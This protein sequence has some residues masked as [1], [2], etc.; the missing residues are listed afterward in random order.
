MET[1]NLTKSFGI[2]VPLD[3]Y[4]KMIEVSTENKITITDICL[5]SL[6]NSGILKS[7]FNFKMGGAVNT[8]LINENKKLKEERVEIKKIAD[9]MKFEF[10]NEKSKLEES[11][12]NNKIL[13]EKE[14]K[15]LSQRIESLES[16]KK[17]L[18]KENEKILEQNIQ[19]KG[20]LHNY[21]FDKQHFNNYDK[22]KYEENIS[23][24]I[25]Q[26]ELQITQ[27]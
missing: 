11:I 4:L 24:H 5:Y 16:D 1:N 21:S 12:K 10:L 2:R 6:A 9:K 26:E 8:D 15:N 18:Q 19:L 20:E 14:M 13:F 23:K 27:R 22:T 7:N 17:T 25:F 3:M